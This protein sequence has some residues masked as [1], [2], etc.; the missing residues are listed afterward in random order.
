MLWRLPNQH[1]APTAFSKL[2]DR[3]TSFE[4]REALA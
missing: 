2:Q 1:A 3:Q 4:L